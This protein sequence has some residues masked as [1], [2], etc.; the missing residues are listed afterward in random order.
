MTKA[1]LTGITG[2]DGYYLSKLL[3]E[4]G[5]EVHGAI[6]RSSSINTSR[7]DDLISI[8]SPNKQLNLHYSDLTDS[9]SLTMLI[10]TIEPDEI[11]NLAAQSHVAVSFKNPMYSTSTSLQGSVSLLEAV[12]NA[13]KDI[14]FYQESSSEMYGG[15][16]KDPLNEMSPFDPKSPYAAGKVLSHNMTKIYR[17]SFGLFCVNGILFNHES[18]H[19]GETF[20]TRKITRAVGR[21]HLGLQEKL[22][23]GNLEA[24][25]DWGFAEDYVYGMWLMM[26]NDTADDWVL[27][28]GETYTV[29]DFLQEACSNID[30]L[31]VGSGQEVTIKELAQKIKD[32]IGF[33]GELKF[34]STMPDGNPRKLLDS[35]LINELGWK[36]KIDLNEGLAKTYKWYIENE[37]TLRS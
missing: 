17:E 19:R 12:R 33:E 25:R 35:S 18:P 32:T 24:S 7:I 16:S 27:A 21:I 3:L 9:S 22:T 26:Q 14:K 2:Q 34:D 5:Y 11:Y 8:Y 30:L 28:T 13:N 6:R 31:N 37:D 23:L 15:A 20:V 36:S 10:N 29:K 1:F 4:K